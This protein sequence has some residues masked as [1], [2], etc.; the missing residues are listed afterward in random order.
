MRGTA[1]PPSRRGPTP[2]ETMGSCPPVARSFSPARLRAV[3]AGPPAHHAGGPSPLALRR[4][5]RPGLRAPRTAPR[6]T[7][8]SARHFTMPAARPACGP[9]RLPAPP[10]ART[11]QASARAANKRRRPPVA[12][13]KL[14][15]TLV[16]A[17]T[18]RHA[19]VASGAHPRH[20]RAIICPPRRT[21]RSVIPD[22]TVTYQG[23]GGSEP[24]ADAAIC[25][26]RVTGPPSRPW[27]LS[28]RLGGCGY[29]PA[30]EEGSLCP[31]LRVTTRC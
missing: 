3:G 10:V 12:L 9:P 19:A 29:R 20:I 5:R 26:D 22:G 4:A 27:P 23:M 17:E 21:R 1:S 11:T 28:R 7:I 24:P 8:A 31:W 18:R 16:S 30:S 6:E 25:R 2:P 14:P 15:L 13:D